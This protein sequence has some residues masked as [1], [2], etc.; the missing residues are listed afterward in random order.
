MKTLKSMEWLVKREFW[1]YKGMFFWA[2]VRLALLMIAL[3]VAIMLYS[4]GKGMSF[5][6]HNATAVLEHKAEVVTAMANSYIAASIPIFM[7]MGALAF[8]YCLGA[9]FEERR[10]RSIL[11]WK[12]LPVSD[13]MTVL[14]KVAVAL[15]VAP[16]ISLG[17][18]I[19][20][21]FVM[22]MFICVVMAFQGINF[23]GALFSNGDFY[24]TPLR[25]IAMW[26]V[27]I[28]W[29]IPTVGWLL[30]VSAWARS[31]VFLWAVGMPL[32]GLVI[33]KM[34][35]FVFKLNLDMDWISHNIMARVLGGLFPGIW[36]GYE[37]GAKGVMINQP[38]HG[39]DMGSMLSNAW[40]SLA[41][42][43]V[44]GG[45]VAGVLMIFVA[46]KLRRWRD[47]G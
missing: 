15:L 16:L 25:L 22:L 14:S 33:L 47:E 30:M 31:K 5:D 35:D 11:F 40:M 13:A 1:E 46:I 17:V 12:S 38:Q 19:V 42:V 4:G 20:T 43:G 34:A 45:V 3:L 32:L 41:D 44:W 2:P 29:A 8:F 39:A 23:L 36:A 27:Y 37:S 6:G 7:M 28:L 21:S 18:G 10:D 24:L 9:M 26:P